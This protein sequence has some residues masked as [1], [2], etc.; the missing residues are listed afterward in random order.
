MATLY[1]NQ[2]LSGFCEEHITEAWTHTD[3]MDYEWV[4]YKAMQK[5]AT[6]DARVFNI[7]KEEVCNNI[8]WRQLD[9]MRNSIQAYGR[10]YFTDRE[11]YK[12]STTDI[13]SMTLKDMIGINY[14]YIS[15]EEAVVLNGR[16]MTVIL[17]GMLM[18]ICVYSKELIEHIL[19]I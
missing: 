12:K 18:N 17:N 4:Y 16:Q 13:K 3:P 6:F 7:P 8:F 19:I 15:K 11:L 1:L 14:V 5:G 2:F 9:A 10:A